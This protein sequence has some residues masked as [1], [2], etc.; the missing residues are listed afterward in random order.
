MGTYAPSADLPSHRVDVVEPGTRLRRHCIRCEI[1]KNLKF[2]TT[3]LEAYCFSNWDARVFDA[4]VLAAAIQFCDHT[5]KRP[6]TSWGRNI[7]LRISVHEPE[8]WRSAPVTEALKNALVFLTGDRWEITFTP[9]KSPAPAPNQPRFNIPNDSCVIIP[10]SDG[11]DSCAAVG[12][13]KREHSNK[14]IPVRL[15][16]KSLNRNAMGGQQHP[17]ALVPYSVRYD[18]KGSFESSSRTRGFKFALLCGIAAYLTHAKQIIMPESGQGSLGPALVPVGQAHKDYR[19][20]PRFTHLMETFIMALFGHEVRYRYPHLWHTKGETLKAFVRD[21]EDGANWKRTRS[22]WRGQRQVSVSRK[23]R[24]CGI[25]AA[26]MLRRMSVHAAGLYDEK[27]TYV[28]ENLN[29]AQFEKGAALAYKTTKPRG[30]N[31]EY[32]I[33]GTLHLDHLANLLCSPAN[34]V[35][36]DLEV[37]QLS[38]S[39]E[40]PEENIKQ[41]LERL[42]K[43]HKEEWNS[44]VTSLGK[45]S[46]VAQWILEA[47]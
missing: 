2:D 40:I 28:W 16:S 8:H 42:L 35:G 25:C 11:L 37:F 33:A 6:S 46:F 24:Q 39:L 21:C 20:H 7:N 31:Y 17:F 41:N 5:K 34:R 13:A 30:A 44:F 3:K 19:N 23:M 26:C 29:A 12:L 32:A 43:K 45:R 22:C 15:G 36:I 14:L 18:K 1:G 38:Q 47:Q 27:E 10:F 4:F 9:R